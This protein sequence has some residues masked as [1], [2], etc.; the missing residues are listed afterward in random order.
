MELV[1]TEGKKVTWAVVRDC[2]VVED[3]NNIHIVLRALYYTL[4]DDFDKTQ[5]E[6]IE[7]YPYLLILV[8]MLP[9]N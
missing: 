5:R 2:I 7:M 4:F 8:I 1:G 3:K 9:G 6:G